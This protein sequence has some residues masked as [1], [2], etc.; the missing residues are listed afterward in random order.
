M[1]TWSKDTGQ[2]EGTLVELGTIVV[3]ERIMMMMN[4]ISLSIISKDIM[5]KINITTKWMA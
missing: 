3:S 2:A 4:Y 5:R 1:R